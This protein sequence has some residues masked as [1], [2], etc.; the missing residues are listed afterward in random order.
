MVYHIKLNKL[1]SYMEKNIMRRSL[2]FWPL[3]MG[4]RYLGRP[5]GVVDKRYA[6]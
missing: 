5:R 4:S 2:C 3:S 1:F 6:L